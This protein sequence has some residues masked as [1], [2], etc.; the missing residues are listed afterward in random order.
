MVINIV[1]TSKV[2]SVLSKVLIRKDF[3]IGYVVSR[4]KEKAVRFVKKMGQGT[5]VSYDENFCL[6]DIVFI[7]VPDGAIGPVYSQ[8]R[9]KLSK[10]VNIY[11]F[12]G[13][14]SSEVFK[15][16]D[17]QG[18]GRG[19]LHPNL[20]FANEKIALRL[21]KKCCFGIE[22]NEKGLDLAKKIVQQIS[23]CW[24]EI[25]KES[26][27]AYHLAAVLASNF[28]V[29]LAYLAEKLYDLYGI[30]G[31]EKIIPPLMLNTSKNISTLG[32]KSSLTGPVARGDWAVV[33]GERK[34]FENCFPEY[35]DLYTS[36]IKILKEIKER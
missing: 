5:P 11:H 4:S 29:G 16:A 24:V 14:L 7:S 9:K 10:D 3:L 17:E 13:F 2:S 31:F 33:E 35:G 20:S 12:S 21:V 23:N 15:D 22:G 19:S 32:V 27:I 18:W 1:G 26:K 30:D 25:P 28:N 34:L 8:L 6:T 36:M